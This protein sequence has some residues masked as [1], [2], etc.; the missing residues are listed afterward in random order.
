MCITCPLSFQYLLSS[1]LAILHSL[2]LSS[3]LSPTR[4]LPLLPHYPPLS[5]PFFPT[6]PHSI[7]P[8]LPHYLHAGNSSWS[9]ADT[10]L[11]IACGR[12]R[13]VQCIQSLLSGGAHID[14]R[15]KDGLTPMHRAAIG[16]NALAINVNNNYYARCI[17][18]SSCCIVILCPSIQ[19]FHCLTTPLPPLPSLRACCLTERPLTTKT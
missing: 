10:P 3:P 18:R 14:F 12:G 2:P 19:H 7:S 1:P 16:G 15:G 17:V 9:Y 11:G 4:S 13:S 6:I 8:F 5:L